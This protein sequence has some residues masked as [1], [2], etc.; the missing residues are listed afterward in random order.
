MQDS[1]VRPDSEE[2]LNLTTAELMQELTSSVEQWRNLQQEIQQQAQYIHRL[3]LQLETVG[4]HV[5]LDGFDSVKKVPAVMPP[6]SGG[7]V[8][9][10]DEEAPEAS[11]DSEDSEAPAVLDPRTAEQI[12]R[13][14]LEGVLMPPEEAG[15]FATSVQRSFERAVRVGFEVSNR[16]GEVPQWSEGEVRTRGF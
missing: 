12:R 9:A 6:L 3:Q 13:E 1:G 10:P 7:E 16:L 2:P 14:A 11:E 8:E 4:I 5:A 15:D